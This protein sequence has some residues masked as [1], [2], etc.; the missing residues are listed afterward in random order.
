MLF[1][2]SIPVLI[3]RLRHDRA[4]EL[5]VFRESAFAFNANAQMSIEPLGFFRRKFTAE[6]QG[7]EPLALLMRVEGPCIGSSTR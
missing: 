2:S 6:R 1:R 4:N 7:V 5:L 3:G